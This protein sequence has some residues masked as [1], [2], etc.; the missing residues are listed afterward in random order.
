M[1]NRRDYL[2][3]IV[4]VILSFG[5]SL[6]NGFAGDDIVKLVNTDYYSNPQNLKTIF[7]K[8]YLISVDQFAR[9]NVIYSGSGEVSYRPVVTLTYFFDRALWGLNPFG[10]H[11]FNLII[12][13]VNV[14]LVYHCL[15]LMVHDNK[16]ALLSAVLF[17][18]HPI[19]AEVVNAI[20]YR[21]GLLSVCFSLLCMI[22]YV[23]YQHKHRRRD[24]V[25]SAGA[26]LIALLA[27]EEAVSVIGVL[28]I[29]R[30]IFKKEKEIPFKVFFLYLFV[31]A[32]YCFIY[33]VVF[34]STLKGKY[35]WASGSL[36]VHAV[37][38]L[39]II[40]YY[41]YSLF[42]PWTI[43]PLPFNF[44]PAVENPI[45]TLSLLGLAAFLGAL[46]APFIVFK[47]NKILLFGSLWFI[48]ALIPFTAIIPT[49]P[50]A[51]R[52]LY[53]PC[54]GIF[55]MMGY[56]ANPVSTFLSRQNSDRGYRLLCI[57]F[58]GLCMYRSS[59][60]TQFWKNN[61]SYAAEI[62]RLYPWD[63]KAYYVLG[64]ENFRAGILA[65]KTN[66]CREAAPLLS[67]AKLLGVND[68]R[69]KKMLEA[70]GETKDAFGTKKE[71]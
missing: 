30:Q 26:L 9:S 6:G 33:F 20:S 12:H 43:K 47:K 59:Y 18:V 7:S 32:L 57:I 56:F 25:L 68:D 4:L 15:T 23:A 37:T 2:L 55:M 22:S 42:L 31:I 36:L 67:N 53:F 8:D 70:C 60:L 11:L 71:N 61:F 45:S 54:I 64:E 48:F 35:L 49:N 52:R 28:F 10:Y 16:I 14:F 58:V 63:K 39:K 3:L 34:P 21:H 66:N 13:L 46:M 19:Q 40:L 17:A 62:I 51:D 44:V 5:H 27:K 69:I 29:Y 24:L 38:I 65:M 41:L 1:N 50:I